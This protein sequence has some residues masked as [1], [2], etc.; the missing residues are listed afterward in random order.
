[1][2]DFLLVG[3]IISV[4]NYIRQVNFPAIKPCDEGT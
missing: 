3:K 4:G 1:M 2:I